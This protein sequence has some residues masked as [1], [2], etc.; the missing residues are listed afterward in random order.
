VR[1]RRATREAP[2]HDNGSWVRTG[3]PSCAR[4]STSTFEHE[5][6]TLMAAGHTNRVIAEE[7]FISGETVK[8]HISHVLRSWR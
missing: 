6:L 1:P 8:R 5:A 2:V 4:F 7:L 3:P